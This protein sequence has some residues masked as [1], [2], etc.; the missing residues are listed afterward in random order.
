MKTLKAPPQKDR[1][2]QKTIGKLLF[3]A[4]QNQM[5]NKPTSQDWPQCIKYQWS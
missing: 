2:V 1:K 3:E 4:E 5:Q